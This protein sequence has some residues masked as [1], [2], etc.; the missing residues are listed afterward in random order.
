ML[1][2][3]AVTLQL[4]IMFGG[5]RIP[6]AIGIYFMSYRNILYPIRIN[7]GISMQ[8]FQ[9]Y[10]NIKVALNRPKSP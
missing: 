3:T 1:G 7:I 9:L 10:R 4:V 5:L 6:I 2:F 8:I